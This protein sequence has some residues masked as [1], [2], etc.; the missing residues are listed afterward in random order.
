MNYD[1]Y[2]ISNEQVAKRVCTNSIVNGFVAFVRE[3]NFPHLFCSYLHYPFADAKVSIMC[4][5]EKL[6]EPSSLLFYEK[7][8]NG[9]EV[10]SCGELC[11]VEHFE[12]GGYVIRNTT[13]YIAVD[14]HLYY[15]TCYDWNFIKKEDLL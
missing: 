1:D 11:K 7:I 12:G 13:F 6:S 4:T 8:M 9:E 2:K 5:E 10:R 14:G 3:N 15:I